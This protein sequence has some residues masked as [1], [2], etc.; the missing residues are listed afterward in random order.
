MNTQRIAQFAQ[1]YL[2]S[3]LLTDG[4]ARQLLESAKRAAENGAD[5][6][7]RQIGID[8]DSYFSGVSGRNLPPVYARFNPSLRSKKAAAEAAYS[9]F[10]S[11]VA[12]RQVAKLIRPQVPAGQPVMAQDPA[13]FHYPH[14]NPAVTGQ[15][16]ALY[17]A[18]M[19]AEFA[20]AALG[21]IRQ[22]ING[23]TGDIGYKSAMAINPALDP[24]RVPE[25]KAMIDAGL[26][27]PA[28]D[29]YIGS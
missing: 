21:N 20:W 8:M 9:S 28:T 1:E 4:L 14:P 23:S 10:F 17:R 11:A 7:L 12:L 5:V 29:Q 2:A 3:A 6:G 26:Y 25:L 19:E 15:P 22:M 16:Q 27:D 13:G 18:W 24:Y